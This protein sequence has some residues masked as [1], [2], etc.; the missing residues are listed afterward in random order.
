M[1]RSSS[2]KSNVTSPIATAWQHEGR[3]ED[4]TGGPAAHMLLFTQITCATRRQGFFL[5]KIFHFYEEGGRAE[6]E[7]ETVS[8]RRHAE[9]GARY[10]AGSHDPASM[11][12]AEMCVKIKLPKWE[13][14]SVEDGCLVLCG[15]L[16]KGQT[17]DEGRNEIR[18]K[19]EEAYSS[20]ISIPSPKISPNHMC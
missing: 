12:W 18:G 11:T 20:G 15:G 6:Q 3:A 19:V 8:S 7:G 2:L 16:M 10:G 14:S 5:V 9:R 17:S 13:A 4:D 1:L